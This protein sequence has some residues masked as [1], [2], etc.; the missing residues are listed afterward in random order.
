MTQS[1]SA[2][3][4]STV[5]AMPP[6][7]LSMDFPCKHDVDCVG[8]FTFRKNKS[9]YCAD[10]GYDP[11]C[12]EGGTCEEG[13]PEACPADCQGF[14]LEGIG[15]CVGPFD[16]GGQPVG[17]CAMPCPA[18]GDCPQDLVCKTVSTTLGAKPVAVCLAPES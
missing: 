14:G 11:N 18:R 2:I 4:D 6:P 16:I 15:K 3:R 13:F 5:K 7:T 8:N 12:C 17:L 9:F 1:A 10:K